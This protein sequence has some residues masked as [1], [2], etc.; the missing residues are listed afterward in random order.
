MNIELLTAETADRYRKELTEFYHKNVCSAAYFTHFTI[1]E[2]CEK[3]GNLIDHL[4]SHTAFVY[5]AFDGKEIIGFLWAYAHQFREENRMYVSEIRVK[6]D[7]RG[8]G[9][10]TEMLKSV[11]AKA[12]EMRFDAIYLHAEAEN[13]DVRKF[14]ETMG[15]REERIQL[16]KEIKSQTNDCHDK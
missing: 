11:E 9:I 12:G 6:E 5:G 7:Y 14:Y 10:G 4:K 8:R 1:E 15:Y 13:T 3:I 2:A 16:R